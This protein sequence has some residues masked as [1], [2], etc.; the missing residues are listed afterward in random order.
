MTRHTRESIQGAVDKNT[1]WAGTCRTL[2]IKPNTGA[3]TYLRKRAEDLGVQF[4]HFL[5]QAWSRGSIQK[6]K[7]LAE[8]L[9]K[10][11]NIHSHALKKRLI[12]DGIKPAYCEVSTC[13]LS[14]W[15]GVEMPLELDHINSDHTDNRI[16]NLQVLCPNCHA[17]KTRQA[18]A[19]RALDKRYAGE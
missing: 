10:G 15:M 3:Q 19:A 14:Q 5:G 13:G 7:P 8:F 16:E 18:R 9:V 2:G 1:T 17:V 4:D 12:R 11:S 6:R